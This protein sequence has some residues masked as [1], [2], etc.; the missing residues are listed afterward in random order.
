MKKLQILFITMTVASISLFS[1]KSS[2]IGTRY[3]GTA[4]VK[5]NIVQV[6]ILNGERKILSSPT[7]NVSETCNNSTAADAKKFLKANI[8][9]EANS[10]KDAIS[11][12]PGVTN[13]W[14][15]AEEIRYSLTTCD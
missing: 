2:T 15:Y 9:S 12:K 4:S 8:E 5:I 13:E 6:I 1:F 7:I 11:F 3:G 14:E 10:K